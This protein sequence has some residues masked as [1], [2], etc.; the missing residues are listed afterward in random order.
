MPIFLFHSRHP[1]DSPCIFI[2][3]TCR[4][5][6]VTNFMSLIPITRGKLKETELSMLE[7]I[8][9]HEGGEAE[10]PTSEMPAAIVVFPEGTRSATGELQ[11]F[12]TGVAYLSIRLGLPIVPVY[13]HGTHSALPK[14]R[15]FPL[16]REQVV[17]HFGKPLF[18]EDYLDSQHGGGASGL[19]GSG[20]R[21]GGAGSNRESL[22]RLTEALR[23]AILDLKDGTM[24]YMET[25]DGN[26]SG[27]LASG[28]RGSHAEG[29]R[30]SLPILIFHIVTVVLRFME[31]CVLEL[32]KALKKGISA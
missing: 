11:R 26:G 32:L 27:D 15:T 6:F 16:R 17:V 12:K 28:G 21:N 25:R 3:D 24:E 5:R 22:Q 19:E 2:Y 8:L 9:S 29:Q 23:S 7:Y 4:A 1:D 13:T 14:G 10:S 18:P 30:W 31:T 20:E